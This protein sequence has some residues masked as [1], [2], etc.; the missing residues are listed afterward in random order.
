MHIGSFNRENEEARID[1]SILQSYEASL[2]RDYV[3]G[4]V[5]S[6]LDEIELALEGVRIHSDRNDLSEVQ[7]HLHQAKNFSA[8][9]GMVT[10]HNITRKMHEASKKENWQEIQE[11]SASLEECYRKSREDFLKAFKL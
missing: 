3:V 10:L 9:M 4:F 5:E 11:L 8:T 2:G 6:C 1:L 7:F